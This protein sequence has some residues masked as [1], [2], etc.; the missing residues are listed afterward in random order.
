MPLQYQIDHIDMQIIDYLLRDARTPYLE[1]A[2]NLEVS[3]GTIHQRVKR[4]K[5]LKI[6][7]GSK[8]IVDYQKLGFDVTVLI[9]IHL[10]SASRNSDIIKK[11]SELPEVTEAYYTTGSFALMIKVM[12]KSIEEYHRFLSK[13]LQLIKEIQSTESFICLSSPIKREL[14]TS[15]FTV[16]KELNK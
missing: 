2:R 6:I 9:A 13:K 10:T 7:N 11:L 3:G 5:E 1:I 8:I 14:S 16:E 12:T 4:L 15:H